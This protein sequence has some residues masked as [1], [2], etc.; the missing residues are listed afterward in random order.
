MEGGD[1]LTLILVLAM[2]IAS[3]G[4]NMYTVGI[5]KIKKDWPKYKCNPVVMPLAGIFGHNPVINF[6]QCITNMQ[7]T[8]MTKYM[9]PLN[10]VMSIFEMT[11]E[12]TLN[13]MNSTRGRM[14]S[15][16]S[17]TLGI[18]TQLFAAFGNI[19]VSFKEI[20]ARL[21][22]TMGKMF[23]AVMVMSHMTEGAMTTG[24]SI[25]NGPVGQSL[26]AANR[27]SK[28]VGGVAK[29]IRDICFH[30]DTRVHLLDGTVKRMADVAVDDVLEDGSVVHATLTL[31]GNKDDPAGCDDN[32]F[33]R[34]RDT[35]HDEDVLVTASHLVYDP[36]RCAFVPVREYPLAEP[37]PDIKVERLSCLITDTHH[38]QLGSI[39]FYDWDDPVECGNPECK[40][41]RLGGT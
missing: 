24:K 32:M 30:N 23:G 12:S 18:F 36:A 15:M 26:R 8:Q 25:W 37:C 41:F 11:I 29:T 40:Q 27:V 4:A 39:K 31:K 16:A 22:D 2:L 13:S 19:G 21:N 3:M 17:G 38:I 9:N 35:K 34:I 5:E 1:I 33:Y 28:T 20:V 7:K 10:H 6:V 14:F